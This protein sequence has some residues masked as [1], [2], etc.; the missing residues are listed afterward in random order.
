MRLARTMRNAFTGRFEPSANRC[1]LLC[2]C[3]VERRDVYA[4]VVARL[5]RRAVMTRDV[6]QIRTKRKAASRQSSVDR[7]QRA[8][9]RLPR[10]CAEG[11]DL[12]S[13]TPASEV[14]N[15]R[16]RHRRD[17]GDAAECAHDRR[18]Q[19]AAKHLLRKD[20]VERGHR[21]PEV[22]E[23]SQLKCCAAAGNLVHP[24]PRT[25][26]RHSRLEGAL[27][28]GARRYRHRQVA[29]LAQPD[30]EA[31][32]GIALDKEEDA[33]SRQPQLSHCYRELSVD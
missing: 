9:D 16:Q 28:V 2:I 15:R 22:R 23:R 32:V 33:R 21:S 30:D 1:S 11:T 25:A 5:G 14:L 26:G 13:L 27:L 7:H 4:V 3:R 24:K 20:D 12:S 29:D 17:D 10:P 6:L 31:D 8:D 18:V 19:R